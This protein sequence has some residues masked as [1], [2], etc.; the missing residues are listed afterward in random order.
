MT[1]YDV[2]VYADRVGM[3]HWHVCERGNFYGTGYGPWVDSGARFTRR[4]A[5]KAAQAA[6]RERHRPSRSRDQKWTVTI[7]G[8]SP[9]GVPYHMTSA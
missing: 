2:K 1:E 4:G 6:I 3:W 5:R 7:E 9:R 8:P